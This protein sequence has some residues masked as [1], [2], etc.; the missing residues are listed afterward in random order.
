[1]K[2]LEKRLE[3]CMNIRIQI[4]QLGLEAHHTQ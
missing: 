1:M 4:K 2:I 3:E